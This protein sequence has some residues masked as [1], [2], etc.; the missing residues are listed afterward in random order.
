[1][2]SA[3]MRILSKGGILIAGFPLCMVNNVLTKIFRIFPELL[4]GGY[5]TALKHDCEQISQ[6]KWRAG[7]S[8][9]SYSSIPVVNHPQGVHVDDRLD[10]QQFL[11]PG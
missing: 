6:L 5:V 10:L 3:S 9:L 7:N 2:K 4:A 8:C 11:G 1:M